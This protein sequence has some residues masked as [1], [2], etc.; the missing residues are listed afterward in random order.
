LPTTV[1]EQMA[2][3]NG[4]DSGSGVSSRSSQAVTTASAST[5]ASHHLFVHMKA[6]ICK[7]THYHPLICLM[8]VYVSKLFAFITGR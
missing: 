8:S 6:A 5:D 4:A 7:V 1:G 3:L 2:L